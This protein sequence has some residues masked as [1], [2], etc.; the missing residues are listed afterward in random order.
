MFKRNYNYASQAFSNL[1]TALNSIDNNN[2]IASNADKAKNELKLY[3][4]TFIKIHDA[5]IELK[6]SAVKL[7]RY[8]LQI[9]NIASEISAEIEYEYK[10]HN[11]LTQTLV[12]QTKLELLITIFI[13]IILNLILIFVVLQKIISPIFHDMQCLS[14][15]DG[16]TGI[17]NRRRFDISIQKETERTKREHQALSLIMCDV[18]FFKDYN[19]IYGH[20]KGD[21]CLQ[22]I[23]HA[24]N[25]AC[26]RPGDLATRYGGEE[27]AIILPNTISGTAMQIAKNIKADID[28]LRIPHKGSSVSPF[29][30]IS[31][32][33]SSI[34]N[35]N[36]TAEEIILRADNALY[37]AKGAGR[38]TIIQLGS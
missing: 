17:A 1:S 26:K 8:Q 18:D 6:K 22:K 11:Q 5:I 30:T 23:A 20:Q 12:Q 36:I 2:K 38:N 4:Q 28:A 31:M 3:Y 35:Q 16:L 37:S 34:I 19:D 24:I 33:I 7:N 32:G 29:V 9:S 10:R 25:K 13:A 14:N 27:F 21:E 15:L